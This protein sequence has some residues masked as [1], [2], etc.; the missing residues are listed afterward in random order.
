[1]CACARLFF[2]AAIRCMQHTNSAPQGI[3]A[4]GVGRAPV[5]V[6]WL[7]LRG[8]PF[9]T[10]QLGDQLSTASMACPEAVLK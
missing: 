7:D 5:T 8:I 4:V 6:P 9:S 10:Q 2:S 3:C 1:V